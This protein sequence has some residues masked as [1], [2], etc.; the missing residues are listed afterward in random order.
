M[1]PIVNLALEVCYCIVVRKLDVLAAWET[2]VVRFD[3]DVESPVAV[4]RR[5]MMRRTDTALRCVV[6]NEKTACA[7]DE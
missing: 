7:Y 5:V 1:E 4:D 2:V 3:A 6:V